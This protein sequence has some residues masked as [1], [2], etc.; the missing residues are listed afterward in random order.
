MK[1]DKI[2]NGRPYGGV[3]VIFKP[4]IDANIEMIDTLSNRLLACKINWK[5]SFLC[6]VLLVNVYMPSNTNDN[7]SEFLD[8]ML[9]IS[10]ILQMYNNCDVVIG[11]DFNCNM[12]TAGDR[13]KMFQDFISLNELV[14]PTISNKDIPYT[15][16]NS[17]NHNSVLDHFCFNAGFSKNIVKLGILDDGENLSDHCPLTVEICLIVSRIFEPKLP[18]SDKYVVCWSSATH[19]NRVEYRNVLYD[20]LLSLDLDHEIINCSDFQ[21]KNTKHYEYFMTLLSRII[22]MIRLATFATIPTK[23]RNCNKNNKSKVFMGWNTYV[24][25]YRMKSVFWHNIWKECG[26]PSNGYIADI[27][28]KTR[29][30]YHSAI[31]VTKNYSNKIIRQNVAESLINNNPKYFWNAINKINKTERSFVNIIDGLTGIDACNV[32]RDKYFEL[33]NKNFSCLDKCLSECDIDVINK[34]TNIE[35]NNNHLHQITS[36][37]VKCSVKTLKRSTADTV[38]DVYS[39][40]F[41]EAPD[42]LFNYLASLYTLMLRHGFT[43]SVFNVIT[44]SPLIKNKRKAANDSDNYRA[45]ALNSSFCKILDKIIINHFEKIFV[46]N[47]RQ[48][49]YKKDN[50]TS[51]CSYIMTEVIQ[52]YNKRSTNVIA[53]FLDCSKAFDQIYYDKLFHIL[54]SKDMCPLITRLLVI[55][56]SNIEARVNWNSYTSSKFSINNGVKQGGVISPLLFVIYTEILIDRVLELNIGCHVGDTPACVMMYADDI[57]LLSPTRSAMQ[58]LLNVCEDYGNEYGLS[59]NPDKSEAVIF[60]PRIKKFYLFLNNKVIPFCD[61][62]K[63]PGHKITNLKN[64]LFDCDS[65]INDLKTR[66]NIILTNFKFLS[67]DARIKIFNSNC[68]SFYGG[69]LMNLNSRDMTKLDTCWRVCCRRLLGVSNRT[70]CS[71]IPYLM[72][73]LPPSLQISLRIINFFGKSS[74]CESNLYSNFFFNQC[75]ILK[76]SLMYNNIKH[77]A[78]NLDCSIPDMLNLSKYNIKKKLYNAIPE[79]DGWKIGLIKE[80]ID[81]KEGFVGVD[82]DSELVKDILNHIC[83]K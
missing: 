72:N 73:S 27:R 21:C 2:S 20:L 56:Y 10:S 40:S 45:I 38:D 70:H 79:I 22:D 61:N 26:R 67:L 78:I 30:D 41:I 66:C 8:I 23:L 43:D 82:F 52:Y 3:A 17:R 25:N 58:K 36:D 51:L 9:E 62:V 32:F 37:M 29:K 80:L 68:S 59:F 6:D 57:V 33:Y 1:S 14:C 83:T 47:S 34:C 18:V 74:Q 35:N 76:E 69:I 48:F 4:C 75:L 13:S 16:H 46:S 77:I 5:N 65:I 7:N 49:A 55:F 12:G 11:G 28:R 19:E 50:S 81:I 53:T 60:G 42:V 64:N 31:A 15:F 54:R 39:D 71:L 63:H 24:K 44:F